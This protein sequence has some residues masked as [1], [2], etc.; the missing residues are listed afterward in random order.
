MSSMGSRRLDME[1]K[2]LSAAHSSMSE[3][4]GTKGESIRFLTMLIRKHA[5]EYLSACHFR[6]S[7]YKPA[8]L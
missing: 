5:S 4:D 7:K 6:L 1:T 3:R 2:E 8:Q